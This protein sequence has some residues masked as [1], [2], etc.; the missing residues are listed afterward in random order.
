M[1]LKLIQ[2]LA[3]MKGSDLEVLLRPVQSVAIVGANYRFACRVCSSQGF[4]K[5]EQ[6][7]NLLL[8]H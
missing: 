3:Q 2:Q 8:E 1:S 7:K 6:L 4:Q 5:G